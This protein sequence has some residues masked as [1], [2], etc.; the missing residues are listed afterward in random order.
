LGANVAKRE[1]HFFV[2]ERKTGPEAPPFGVNP[3]SAP[4]LPRIPPTAVA[5]QII[6][7]WKSLG[8][9]VN[10]VTAEIVIRALPECR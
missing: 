3:L 1:F 6:Y 2:F 5:Q 8:S 4:G 7:N 9:N 10:G